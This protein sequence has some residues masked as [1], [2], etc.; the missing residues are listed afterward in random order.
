MARLKEK[1]QKE[2]VPALM[3][4]FQYKS[5]MAVPKLVKIVV[6]MGLGE[7]ISNPKLLDAASEE[8]AAITGQKPIIRRAKK[9]IA[10]F[11]LRQGMPIGVMVTVRGDRMYEF[12]DRL[13]NIV[14]PRMRDFRGVSPGA[15]DGKGNYT[16]G[17]TD[18]QIFPELDMGTTEQIRGMNVTIV[19]TAQADEEAHF[20][21]A[22]L[23]VPFSK[24]QEDRALAL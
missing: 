19:T 14:M 21:L 3:K 9:A 6:N 13:V 10:A 22:K 24:K 12:F 7:A 1:Y 5:V 16:I 2:I 20:M 15:F 4:E 23:G 8:L 11:K 18:Q 17:L